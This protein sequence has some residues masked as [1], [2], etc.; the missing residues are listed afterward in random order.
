M[1]ERRRPPLPYTPVP[2]I[3]G[4]NV[5]PLI[6]ARNYSQVAPTAAS[7]VVYSTLYWRVQAVGKSYGLNADTDLVRVDFTLAYVYRGQNYYY[8]ALTFKAQSL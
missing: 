2:G 1:H 3:A 6:V 5:L 7:L 4:S 8:K